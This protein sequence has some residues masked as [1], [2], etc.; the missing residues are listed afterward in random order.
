MSIGGPSAWGVITNT[1]LG[2][3]RDKGS[4]RRKFYILKLDL[5]DLGVGGAF[6]IGLPFPL[7]RVSVEAVESLEECPS[8]CFKGLS[9]GCRYKEI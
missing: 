1:Y 5:R 3:F 6:G 8:A 9:V 2:R 4:F 7:S